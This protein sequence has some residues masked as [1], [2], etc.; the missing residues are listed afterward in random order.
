MALYY[1]AWCKDAQTMSGEYCPD[2]WWYCEDC[3]KKWYRDEGRSFASEQLAVLRGRR[4]TPKDEG[5]GKD[6]DEDNEED[7]DD[8]VEDDEKEDEADDADED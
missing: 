5:K 6:N 1:C 8:K 4:D 2:G 3:W 7:D